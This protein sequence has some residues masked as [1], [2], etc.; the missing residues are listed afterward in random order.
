LWR[1]EIIG[2]Y[3]HIDPDDPPMFSTDLTREYVLLAHQGFSWDEL[4][5]LNLNALEA[6]FLSDEEKT[7]YRTEWQ[8]FTS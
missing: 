5:Q 7:I 3:G 6:S 8:T 4:W 1:F 2:V